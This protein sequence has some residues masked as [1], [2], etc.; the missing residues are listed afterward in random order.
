MAGLVGFATGNIIP[1]SARPDTTKAVEPVSADGPFSVSKVLG[2]SIPIVI[3]TGKVD[4]APVIGGAVTVSTS[5]AGSSSSGVGGITGFATGPTLFGGQGTPATTTTTVPTSSTQQTAQLGYLLAY[6]PFGD[7]YEL[8]RL[9][10]DDKVVY[11]AENGIGASEKFRFYGGTQTTVDPITKSVIG[12]KAGAWQGFALVFLDGYVAN[13][14]PTVKAVISNAATDAPASG[15]IAWTG[16]APS[17]VIDAFPHG[18][19]YDP[20]ENVIYQILQPTD[21][22]GL[23]QIY[24]A[25]LEVDTRVERYRVPLQGSEAYAVGTDVIDYQLSVPITMRGS[26]LIMVQLSGAPATPRL[27]GIWDI[28]TGALV[29]SYTDTVN[30]LWLT[31]LPIGQKWVFFGESFDDDPNCMAAVFDP[32]TASLEVANILASGPRTYVAVN[33]RV[34]SGF[35]SFFSATASVAGAVDVYELRFDG[36]AWSAVLLASLTGVTGLS[37]MSSGSIL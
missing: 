28:A 7:G 5:T 16:T 3:G 26:G 33:G 10:I 36:D 25:V 13:N 37:V 1:G 15:V 2:R 14:A 9:E 31:V 22:P 4:G 8:I 24:L 19:C 12:T 34:T 35:T 29:A 21:I 11:D 32:A 18:S 30:M 20:A 17:G 27:T 6:D 23:T